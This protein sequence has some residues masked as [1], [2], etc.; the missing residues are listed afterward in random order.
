MREWRVSIAMA[1]NTEAP[2]LAALRAKGYT[3]AL[4]YHRRPGGDYTREF[5]AQRDDRRFFAFGAEELLGLVAM[6]EV[7]GDDWQATRAERDWRDGLAD[8]APEFDEDGIEI[9]D[10][11]G[12]CGSDRR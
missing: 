5:E 9:A 11:V 8:S 3:I 7:R 6:W 4:S 10:P 2:A 1:G 12:D